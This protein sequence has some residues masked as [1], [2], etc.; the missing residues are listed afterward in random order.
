MVWKSAGL[1]IKFSFFFSRYL[2]MHK[3]TK[4]ILCNFIDPFHSGM[5]Y[6]FL[7]VD[8]NFIIWRSYIFPNSNIEILVMAFPYFL[9]TTHAQNVV[10]LHLTI[11]PWIFRDMT[12][13][14]YV[15]EQQSATLGVKQQG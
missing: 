15:R 14:M 12:E 4:S 8:I 2:K 13:S 9:I 10:S 7:I 1:A 11:T 3:I 5:S 6:C